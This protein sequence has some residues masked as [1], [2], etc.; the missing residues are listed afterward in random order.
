[1]QITL[2]GKEFDAAMENYVKTLGFDTTRY[3][4]STKTVVGR[5]ESSSTTVTITLDEC[6]TTNEKT[7][8]NSDIDSIVPEDKIVTP[9]WGKKNES[10]E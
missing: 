5:G 10:T 4:I 1:M 8:V 9:V 6:E 3:T 7:Y 2:T